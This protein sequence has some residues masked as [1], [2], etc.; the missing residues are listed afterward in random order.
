MSTKSTKVKSPRAGKHSRTNTADPGEILEELGRLVKSY[1]ECSEATPPI[2]P[3]PSGSRRIDRIANDVFYLAMRTFVAESRA[4]SILR[5]QESLPA[6]QLDYGKVTDA[7]ERQPSRAKLRVAIPPNHFSGVV[8]PVMSPPPSADEFMELPNAVRGIRDSLDVCTSERSKSAQIRKLKTRLDEKAEGRGHWPP[9]PESK[10]PVI[11][12]LETDPIALS[13][14]T[15]KQMSTPHVGPPI[16]G[17]SDTYQVAQDIMRLA[18]SPWSSPTPESLEMALA[19]YQAARR[20]QSPNPPVYQSNVPNEVKSL[21]Q[22][23]DAVTEELRATR[24]ELRDAREETARALLALN[25]RLEHLVDSQ[26]GQSYA[27]G[28]V[29]ESVQ[30]EA[31]ISSVTE[32][33][34]IGASVV[35]EPAT[36]SMQPGREVVL[37]LVE[38]EHTQVGS[39]ATPKP[40][41][42]HNAP[43]PEAPEAPWA[44]TSVG[45]NRLSVDESSPEFVE[46]KVMVLL[47]KLS[48][49]NFDSVSTQ[50]VNWANKSENETDCAT[51]I[52]VLKL[53][54][55]KATDEPHW[56]EMYAKLCRK[57]MDTISPKVHAENA[58]NN[59]G[60][61]VVGGQLFRR[62]L[63]IR[64]QEDFE[65]GW[66]QTEGEQAQ[67]E[68]ELGTAEY[69]TRV[70]IKRQGLGLVRFIG[71]LFKLQMLTD[72]VIHECIKNLLPSETE[73]PKEAELETLCKLLTTVGER[74]DVPKSKVYMDIYFGRIQGVA[75]GSNVASRIRYMIQDVVEL[76]QR[77]WKTRN[78][79]AEPATTNQM[80]NQLPRG[81]PLSVL[82][83]RSGQHW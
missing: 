71:E 41:Q 13:S 48:T 7:D 45:K 62:F 29:T 75:Y 18:S 9:A 61:L 15:S 1:A 77:H 56:A 57:M 38:A 37:T 30:E 23:L 54:F 33:T 27:F 21:Q 20:V 12:E 39:D 74:L 80:H 52:L 10:S 34:V 3:K 65:R 40:M 35:E 68:P 32:A 44:P 49:E 82:S 25:E 66:S 73:D 6:S 81:N 14:T 50:I 83:R 8:V 36:V 70:K 58:R 43:P 69:Y 24:E 76:R 64:C 4:V 79:E 63:L 55:E 47:N 72:R 42:P 17:D 31:P 67:P 16:E 22:Q 26:V 53:V 60:Q 2:P 78:T 11:V 28:S 46:R 59:T 19:I 5:A 51:L